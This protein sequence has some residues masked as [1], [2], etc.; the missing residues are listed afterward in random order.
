[1]L[2]IKAHHLLGGIPQLL[3]ATVGEVQHFV[4]I[5]LGVQNMYSQTL[6]ANAKGR[7]EQSQEGA[8]EGAA[9]AAMR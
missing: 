9:V 6:S 2:C 8:G 4:V 3:A 7:E 5:M 1:M